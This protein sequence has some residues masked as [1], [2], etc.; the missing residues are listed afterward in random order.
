MPRLVAPLGRQQRE[1]FAF[2]KVIR[3][4]PDLAL[5]AAAQQ[6]INVVLI[7]VGFGTLAGLL[8]TVILP[9]RRPVGP[10]SCLVMGIVGSTIGLLGLSWLFPD[11]ELNPISPLGFLAAPPAPSCCW[12]STASAQCCWPRTPTSRKR[13]SPHFSP[14]LAGELVR[15]VVVADLRDKRGEQVRR[16]NN[17]AVGDFPRAVEKCG[18]ARRRPISGSC[19]R[20]E[21]SPYWWHGT[22]SCFSDR[23]ASTEHLPRGARQARRRAAGR[24][25]PAGRRTRPAGGRAGRGQDAGRQGHR[26]QPR[27]QVPPHPVHA[28]PA[29]GRHHRQQPLQQPDAGVRLQSRVRSSPTSC[30]PTR[31]TAPRR[32]R[33][34]PC[35]RR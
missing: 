1:D 7:W 34:A 31:S 11:R 26:P 20:R 4:M 18:R 13:A 35:W 10:F 8:A 15:R 33:R 23:T 5:S 22:R 19:N 9:F 27:R 24:G 29:A 16:L 12:F 3:S 32:A 30:W 21:I 17:G 28:R 14:R 2:I 6:W 25:G